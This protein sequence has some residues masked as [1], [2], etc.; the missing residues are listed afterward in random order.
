[1]PQGTSGAARST[2]APPLKRRRVGGALWVL[3]PTQLL[4]RPNAANAARSA[5]P[6]EGA[7]HDPGQGVRF[8]SALAKATWAPPRPPWGRGPEGP[9][10]ALPA[11]AQP[12]RLSPSSRG[13]DS[14]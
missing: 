2:R 1:M 7:L 12:V 13:P 11:K 4:A 10:R 14:H 3:A 6:F 9:A 5:R 8:W